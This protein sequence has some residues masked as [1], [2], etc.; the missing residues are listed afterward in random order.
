MPRH[1]RCATPGRLG[2][3]CPIA[4]AVRRSPPHKTP[5]GSWPLGLC[6]VNLW[7]LPARPRMRWPVITNARLDHRRSDRGLLL[8]KLLD[9][10]Q[11]TLVIRERCRVE[12]LDAGV[13]V[14]GKRRCGTRT[15]CLDGIPRRIEPNPEVIKLHGAISYRARL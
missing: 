9:V 7:R 11:W 10:E 12:D 8:T 6:E 13:V 2:S 1:Q 15:A 4:D 14:A 5:G 3:S